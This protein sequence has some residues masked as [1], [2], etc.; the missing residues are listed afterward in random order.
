MRKTWMSVVAV[1]GLT[2]VAACGGSESSTSE[3]PSGPGARP[4]APSG[5][6]KA[7]NAKE[8]AADDGAAAELN[9]KMNPFEKAQTEQ[10]QPSISGLHFASR[11]QMR[12]FAEARRVVGD[13]TDECA[14]VESGDKTDA[15]KDEVPVNSTQTYN[16][17]FDSGAD[18][19]FKMKMAI[20]GAV[21][22]ADED[23]AKAFPA[24]GGTWTFNNF[25]YSLSMDFS[26]ASQEQQQQ[27]P[28]LSINSLMNGTHKMSMDADM[29][30]TLEI[31]MQSAIKNTSTGGQTEGQT[32]GAQ[33][34]DIT[35]NEWVTVTVTPD[36]KNDVEKSGSMT[37]DGFIGLV[38][39]ETMNLKISSSDLKYGCPK[40][41]ILEDEP[42]NYVKSGSITYEDANA[43]KLTFTWTNCEQ[44]PKATFNGQAI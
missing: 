25:N 17:N 23:D 20:T 42:L 43:N 6:L 16:C 5:E 30:S 14:P 18:Q 11:E 26:G 31:N 40:V 2:V 44:K 13:E 29:K 37:I 28:T 32:E 15:D 41:Y 35:T 38:S 4:S 22:V 33:N 12:Q 9:A 7:A 21:S 3:V 39:T 24:K 34:V 36:D 27:M 10:D 19:M 8:M 1:A